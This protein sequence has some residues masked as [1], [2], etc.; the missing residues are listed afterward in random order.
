MVGL[1]Q[2]NY[3]Y[4]LGGVTPQLSSVKIIG[5][6]DEW[7]VIEFDEK[8]YSALQEFSIKIVD[9]EEIFKKAVNAPENVGAWN[10]GIELNTFGNDLAKSMVSQ[11]F[12][13]L[14]G[15]KIEQPDMA[16]DKDRRNITE[17]DIEP[18]AK[19]SKYVRR[20]NLKIK[21]RNKI[22]EVKDLEDDLADSK[23]LLNFALTYLA[24]EW[25]N[26]PEGHKN[27]NPKR[28]EMDILA[29]KI[30]S[31]DFIKRNDKLEKMK[32][33]FEEE[34]KINK[35]VKENYFNKL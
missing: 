12:D 13:P 15:E 27:M 16:D 6:F 21:T 7:T 4:Q 2:D 33:I 20:F 23:F 14:T 3:V 11:S 31:S 32:K 30:S 25:N 5:Q 19:A 8:D 28:K 26:K 22:K 34:D 10:E 35:I 29:E 9:D 17:E 24:E 18:F 1:I